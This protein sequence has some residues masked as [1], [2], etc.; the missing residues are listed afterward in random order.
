M[1]KDNK[2]QLISTISAG[3]SET[4]ELILCLKEKT[5]PISPDNAIGRISQERLTKLKYAL[6]N[7]DR[8]DFGICVECDKAI[9]IGR[10]MVMPESNL[11]VSCAEMG[12]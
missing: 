11:C 12:E 9:P 7:I 2:A 5:K 1:D 6:H 4:E 3:I 10:I 8:P